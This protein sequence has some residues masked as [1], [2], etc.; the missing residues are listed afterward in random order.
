MKDYKDPDLG[1]FNIEQIKEFLKDPDFVW[2]ID[3][4]DSEIKLAMEAG[5]ISY[6]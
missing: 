3:L 1:P 4:L 6:D 5:L 2:Y